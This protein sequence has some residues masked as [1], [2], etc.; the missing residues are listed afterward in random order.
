M[1]PYDYDVIK[2]YKKKIWINVKVINVMMH[3]MMF[4]IRSNVFFDLVSGY[5]YPN[6]KLVTKTI[7]I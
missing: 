2:M 4:T 1:T 3:T 7:K 6:K 5:E